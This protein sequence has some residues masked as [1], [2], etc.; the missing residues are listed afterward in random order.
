M[1]YNSWGCKESGMIE[2]TNTFIGQVKKT[3]L[4]HISFP[5]QSGF[6]QLQALNGILG[7]KFGLGRWY[8]GGSSEAAAEP[9]ILSVYRGWA[10]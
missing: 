2:A 9:V 8:R 5:H 10:P 1:G 4:G 3:P 7:D 6:I